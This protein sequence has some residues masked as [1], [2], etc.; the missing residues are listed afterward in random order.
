MQIKNCFSSPKLKV[1]NTAGIATGNYKNEIHKFSVVSCQNLPIP[2]SAATRPYVI[3]RNIE[4]LLMTKNRQLR[5]MSA[6][7]SS[8]LQLVVGTCTYS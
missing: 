1:D 2:G 4:E 8:Q 6:L 7:Q 3:D 5:W